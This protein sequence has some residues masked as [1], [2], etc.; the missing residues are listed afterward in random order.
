MQL[1]VGNIDHEV[2]EF[3]VRETDHNGGEI[4]E[5]V[6]KDEGWDSDEETAGRGH[7]H[8][9]D[10]KGES[11]RIGDTGGTENGERTHHSDNRSQQPDHGSD[12]SDNRNVTDFCFNGLRLAQ[13]KLDQGSLHGILTATKALKGALKNLGHIG[14]VGFAGLPSFLVISSFDC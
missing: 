7:E 9:T 12:N 11:A 5:V 6:I 10:S 1:L 2:L 4:S 14:L 13:S 3:V 8:L